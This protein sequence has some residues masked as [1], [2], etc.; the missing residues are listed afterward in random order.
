MQLSRTTA[1][2]R[3]AAAIGYIP[4]LFF[5]PIFARR[6]DEFAQFHGKQ[7]LILF[8]VF[9]IAWIAIWFLSLIFNG[10]LSHIIIIGFLFK[11]LAW[12][13]HNLV[14]TVISIGYIVLAIL[15]IIKASA[16]KYW[17]IPVIS[18]YSERIKI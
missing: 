11:A 5:I 13:I 6:E 16:G 17:R 7:S 14:G 8:G 3:V 1:N 12:L 10:I 2:N 4:F 18:A 15:G 9:I